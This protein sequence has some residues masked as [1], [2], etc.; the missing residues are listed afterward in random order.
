[1]VKVMTKKLGEAFYKQK[2]VVVV[3]S[4]RNFLLIF[5]QY[6]YIH[7]LIDLYNIKFCL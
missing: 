4:D 3:C 6:I 7:R 5:L 2:G 1:M